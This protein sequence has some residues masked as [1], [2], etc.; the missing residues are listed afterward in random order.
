MNKA[1]I[2]VALSKPVLLADG[3]QLKEIVLREPTA[4][5]LWN[6]PVKSAL[7][8]GDLLEMAAEI[9]GLP[10]SSLKTLSA[11]DAFKVVGEVGK[12]MGGGTGVTP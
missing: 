5:D 11:G 6:F 3:T 8:M 9:S 10:V 1:P 4:E 12:F 7:V 2:T